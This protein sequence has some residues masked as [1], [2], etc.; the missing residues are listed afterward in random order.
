MSTAGDR[1]LVEYMASS[2]KSSCRGAVPDVEGVPNPNIWWP[3]HV[4]HDRYRE[5]RDKG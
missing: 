3:E 2:A 5:Q 1:R 4:A